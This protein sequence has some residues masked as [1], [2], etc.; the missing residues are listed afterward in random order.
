MHRRLPCLA[1]AATLTLFLG[2]AT[3]ASAEE[4]KPSAPAPEE[5]PASDETKEEPKSDTAEAPADE[6]SG[7]GA[8]SSP[9]PE[10]EPGDFGTVAALEGGSGVRVQSICTNCNQAN[11]TINGVTGEQHVLVTFDDVPAAGGLGTV[12]ALNQFP[13]DL[14]GYTHVTRGPGTVQSGSGGMG[15]TIEFHSAPRTEQQRG[16]LRAELGDWSTRSLKVAGADRWG[17]VGALV[18][19]QGIDQ[20]EVDANGDGPNEVGAFFRQTYH[21]LFDFHLTERQVLTVNGLYYGEDQEAGPGRPV[22]ARNTFLDEDVHFNWHQYGLTWEHAG[23]DGSGV[24]LDVSTSRRF[25]AQFL[26][27]GTAYLTVEDM[28]EHARLEGKVPLPHGALFTAAFGY[29]ETRAKVFNEAA[30]LERYVDDGLEHWELYAQYERGLGSHWDFSVGARYDAMTVFGRTRTFEEDPWI[31][32]PDDP[33]AWLLPRATVHWKPNAKVVVG[34]STG[35]FA[36]GPTPVFEKTCCGAEFSRAIDLLP[37]QAWSHQLQV[38]VHPTQDMRLTATIYQSDFDDYILRTVKYSTQGVPEYTNVNVP[39]ARVKGWDL[40]HDMRFKGNMFNVG[41]T[42]TYSSPEDDQ[43]HDLPYL[44]RRAASAYLRFEHVPRGAKASLD[45]RWTGPVRHYQLSPS[46]LPFQPPVG[47]RESEDFVTAD[48]SYEQRIGK[49]GWY[50]QAGITNL[51][52]YVMSDL[53]RVDK[54]GNDIDDIYERC[55]D[56]GPITGRYGWVAVKWSR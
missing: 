48:V 46:P 15:G 33:H 41:W 1:L 26:P 25:Q 17:P 36:V 28:K 44:A 47:Y 42:Y 21:G 3:G 56:W 39:S 43:G 2:L 24:K 38:E 32:E 5:A 40:V 27:S 31:V 45:A 11:L 13:A 34:L 18:Y 23:D 52:D 10:K 49:K 22:R 20:D 9:S 8:A 4:A 19:L 30:A 12:Y 37:E 16:F 29:Q 55:F 6:A 14:V 7:A 50:V 53:D 51:T 54:N 35:R